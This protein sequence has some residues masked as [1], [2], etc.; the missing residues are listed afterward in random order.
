MA[1]SEPYEAGAA[2]FRRGESQNDNPHPVGTLP[3]L[4]WD[5]G[6]RRAEWEDAQ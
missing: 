2:A 1:N 5:N 4:S 3:A 6:W